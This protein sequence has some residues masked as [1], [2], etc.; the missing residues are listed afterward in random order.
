MVHR[1]ATFY[2]VKIT[3]RGLSRAEGK[4]ADFESDPKSMSEIAAHIEKLF[5]SGDRI[6]KKGRTDKSAKYYLSDMRIQNKQLILLINRSDPGAPDAVSTDP[7]IKSRVVHEKPPGHGGD[8]STHVVINIEP[9]KGDNYYLCV[10]ET[11]YG[12]GLHASSVGDYLRFIVRHCKKQ[13]PSEYAVAHIDGIVSSTGKPVLVHLVHFIEMQGH[14]SEEFE[15]DLKTGTL[16]AI[17]LLNF[18]KEGAA[19]DEQGGIVER[20]RSVELRPQKDMLGD[21]ASTLRT[22]RNKVTVQHEE[23]KH[24]RLRFKNEAGEPKDA[25]VSTE[26]GKLVDSHKYVR[27]HTISA[28]MVN[29]A[30]LD[31]INP[32]ILKEVL[33]L[34]V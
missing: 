9:V 12:S 20:K 26:T 2:D 5:I 24:I 22:L 4:S 8:Y 6:I 25:T 13:F 30:S 10:I 14:P 18:S 7:E 15:N 21:L 28:L 32:F 27:R 33:A 3:A 34:M 19:W 17:D 31:T 16:S 11:V 29:T 23:Y 1:T